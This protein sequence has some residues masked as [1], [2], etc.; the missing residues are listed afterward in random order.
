M[1]QVHAY[2]TVRVPLAAQQQ[3]RREDRTKHEEKANSK[4]RSRQSTNKD[5]ETIVLSG[6]LSNS[7]IGCKFYTT[8]T[9][10]D[11][12]LTDCAS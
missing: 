1:V 4:R 3:S 5:Q 2:P 7:E 12:C 6:L 9:S 8:N 10:I 11:Y